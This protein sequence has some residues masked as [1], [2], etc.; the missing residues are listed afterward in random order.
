VTV[1][2]PFMLKKLLNLGYVTG[3]I[4]V[5]LG[6]LYLWDSFSTGDPWENLAAISLIWIGFFTISLGRRL[7]KGGR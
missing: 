2:V 5:I 4:G 7:E 1:R 3:I 6:S